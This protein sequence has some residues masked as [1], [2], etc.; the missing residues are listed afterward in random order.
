MD[1]GVNRKEMMSEV[2]GKDEERILVRGKGR[3]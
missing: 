2:E 3:E 1:G